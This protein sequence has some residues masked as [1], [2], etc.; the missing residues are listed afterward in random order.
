VHSFAHQ[1]QLPVVPWAHWSLLGSCLAEAE[2]SAE[3]F[4]S[5]PPRRHDLFFASHVGIISDEMFAL[6]L[7]HASNAAVW[8]ER[9]AGKATLRPIASNFAGPPPSASPA[10]VRKSTFSDDR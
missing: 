3:G 10:K 9:R 6:G 7:P 1:A 8:L 2:G 5:R 4:V